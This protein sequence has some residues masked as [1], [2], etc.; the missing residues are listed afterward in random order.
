MFL[1]LKLHLQILQIFLYWNI[2]QKKELFKCKKLS[3]KRRGFFW[4]VWSFLRFSDFVDFFSLGGPK[5][6]FWFLEGFRQFSTVFDRV[7]TV[8]R[9]FSTGFRQFFDN[10]S[11]IFRWFQNHG[12]CDENKLSVRLA[13]IFC[14]FSK[15]LV[16]TTTSEILS[17]LGQLELISPQENVIFQS[18]GESS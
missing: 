11:R 12:F 1:F 7:S 14:S 9:Q 17:S 4:G 16:S 10:F 15:E 13:H 6:G 18:F 2:L 3:A 8:F 5:T